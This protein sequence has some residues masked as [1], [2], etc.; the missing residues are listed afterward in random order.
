MSS[1]GPTCKLRERDRLPGR[2]PA[3]S[4]HELPPDGAQAAT[5]TLSDAAET[6]VTSLYAQHRTKLVGYVKGMT[7]DAHL[8]EEIVQ[9]T[10]LRT[11]RNA[12]VLSQQRGSL[13]G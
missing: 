9:E 10:M 11:W 3:A 12:D 5:V 2:T 13:W 7:S 8:A 4:Q 6:F 1:I